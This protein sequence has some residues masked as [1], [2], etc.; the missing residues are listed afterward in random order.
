MANHRYHGL[1]KRIVRIFNTVGPRMRP[2]NGRVVSDFVV[3]A[4]QARSLT[5]FG[6]GSQSRSFCYVHDLVRGITALLLADSDKTVEQRTDRFTFLAKS[7]RPLPETIHDSVNICNP[8]ELTVKKIADL[9]LTGSKRRIEHKP[10][11]QMIRRCGGPTFIRR[12]KQLLG[13][14]PQ[15][16][17]KMAKE[18]P[19]SIFG[20][21]YEIGAI[22]T[23][24]I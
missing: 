16:R 20:R 7:A 11:R 12:A 6:D 8:C 5:I 10:L 3:Q 9:V 1:D 13:W 15:V 4:L 14:E 24:E 2:N 18:R 22:L 21:L 23:E 19:S 17:L